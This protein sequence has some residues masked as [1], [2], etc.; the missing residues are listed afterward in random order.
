MIIPFPKVKSHDVYGVIN[1]NMV[2]KNINFSKT[3][4]AFVQELLN[5]ASTAL[6]AFQ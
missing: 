3:D 2:R 4:I 6:A 5:L 1:L